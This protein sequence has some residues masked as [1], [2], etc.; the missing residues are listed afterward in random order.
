MTRGK[1]HL[2]SFINKGLIPQLVGRGS[3]EHFN[4]EQGNLAQGI[5]HPINDQ[6]C[7]TPSWEVVSHCPAPSCDVVIAPPLPVR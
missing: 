5:W 7:P 1:Y 2:G 4:H 3:E 6:N